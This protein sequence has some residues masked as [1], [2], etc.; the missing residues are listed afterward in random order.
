MRFID[1]AQLAWLALVVPVILFFYLLKLRRREVVVSSVLLWSYVLRDLQANAP[2]QRLRRNLLL[3]LQLAVA[4]LAIFALARPYAMVPSLGG[5]SVVVLLDATA[6]MQ[7]RDTPRGSRFEQA[8]AEVLRMVDQMRSGDRM[9]VILAGAQTRTLTGGFTE[10]RALLRRALRSAQP[11]DAEGDLREAIRLGASIAAASTRQRGARIVAFSDGAF[12]PL[13]AIDLRGSE[14]VFARVGQRSENLAIVAMDVRRPWWSDPGVTQCF[15]AV[16]NHGAQP[17]QAA[18]ELYRDD[19]LIDVRPLRLPAADRE[20]GFSELAELF[21]LPTGTGGILRA[22]I[23]LADDLDVDN[24]AYA[25]LVPHR[26]VRVLLVTARDPEVSYLARALATDTSVQAQV[27]SPAGYT[28]QEGYDVVVFEGVSPRSVGP[29][30]Y[31]YVDATGET[32]PAEAPRRVEHVGITDWDRTHPVMRF[33][34]LSQVGADSAAAAR[35]RGWGRVIASH[36]GGAA[37]VAGDRQDA[38]VAGRTTSFRAL[39]LSFPIERSNFWSTVAFPIFVSNAV[40]W[41]ATRP[42]QREGLH[43]RAG[44]V[45]AVDVPDGVR[46]VTVTT[47]TGEKHA[48]DVPGRIAYFRDTLRRGVYEIAA[49]GWRREFVVNLLSR[50]ESAIAPRDTIRLGQQPVRAADRHT[51]APLEWWRWLVLLAVV[52][53]A[54]EWWVYHRRL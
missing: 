54:V 26:A 47:P 37:V 21:E 28:G 53:L 3:W 15:I 31:L 10:D 5:Q 9:M 6:S 17:R 23:D 13:E 50:Q 40:Q 33:V 18:L 27:V 42:G 11:T 14:L 45:A 41:L 29:G 24:E 52:I 51:R 48:I 44:E 20:L 30:N 32:C 35:P 49:P 25:Q 12:P 34:D 39:Y 22:R 16:R 7:A 43:L 4:G 36:E 19:R 38:V 2:F 1:P 46:R 8:R